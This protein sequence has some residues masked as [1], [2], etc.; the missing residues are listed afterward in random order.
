MAHRRFLVLAAACW[1][2]ILSGARADEECSNR[3][4][5]DADGWVDCADVDCCLAPAC[6]PRPCERFRRGDVDADGAWTVLD[7]IRVILASTGA[8]SRLD[9][10]D[11]ADFDDDGTLQLADAVL[12]L[13]FIFAAGPAPPEPYADCGSDP[14]TDG[15]GNLSCDFQ[16]GQGC[17]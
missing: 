13:G 12:L 17:R 1:A 4:D 7:A 5:D 10:E 6:R 11:S 3:V 2:L 15:A 9:C 16:F 8:E 14:T